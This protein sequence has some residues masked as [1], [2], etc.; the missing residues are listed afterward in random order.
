MRVDEVAMDVELIS[1]IPLFP[2]SR[3]HL[4]VQAIG[5]AQSTP[6][7]TSPSD[8]PGQSRSQQSLLK[9]Y[10]VERSHL[11]ESTSS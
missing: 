9:R 6:L 11:S 8:M 4:L 1:A 3:L 2:S 5:R 10:D 7:S